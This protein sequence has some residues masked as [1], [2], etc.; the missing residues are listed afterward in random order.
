MASRRSPRDPAPESP[1][2]RGDAELIAATRDGDTAAYGELYERHV[3][4]ARRLGR[5]LARDAAAADDLVSETFAKVL[6]ALRNGNGPDLAFRAYL[7]TTLRHTFY[8]RARRDRRVEFTDDMSKHDPGVAFVDTAVAGQERRFAARAFQ[9]LPERWQV[10]LWHTEVEGESAAEIAPMLGLTPNAVAAL[11]YRAREKLRQMYLQEHL[12]AVTEAECRWTAGRLG[13]RVRGGLSSRDAGKVDDHLRGC[14][15]CGLALLELAE[16]NSGFRELLAFLVV[17]GSAPAYLGAAGAVKGAVVI[18]WWGGLTLGLAEA[19][20]HVIGWIRTGVE[21]VGSRTATATGAG[22]TVIAAVLA[23]VMLANG[24]APEPPQVQPPAEQP[25]PPVDPPEDDP[26]AEDPPPDEE[27]ADDP[28][29]EEPDEPD[30]AP[31]P[32]DYVI[33]TDPTLSTLV[34][35]ADGSLP[36]ELSVP[37]APPG[38]TG[39]VTEAARSGRVAT[40][41]AHTPSGDLRLV[42]TLPESIGGPGGDA[43]D[44]W[45]CTAGTGRVE[46]HR[47]ALRPGQ[48]TVARVPLTI[49]PRVTGFHDIHAEVTGPRI[50]GAAAL[51]VPIA[52][53]GTT[54]AFAAVDATGVTATGNGWLTCRPGPMCLHPLADNHTVDLQPYL[55]A[56]GRP[57]GLDPSAAASGARLD[58]PGGAEVLWAG[59]HWANSGD[60]P[61][62]SVR[63]FGPGG[64]AHDVAADREW[65]GVERP[66]RQAAADVTALVTG[67][68]DYWLATDSADIPSGRHQYA[69]WSMTVVYRVAGTPPRET[70][71][72]EGLA[73]PRADDELTVGIPAGGEVQVAYTLWDGDRTLL[74]DDLSVAGRPLGIPANL[75]HS[76]AYGALE[77][78]RRHTFGVDVG[79]CR[80]T[81]SPEPTVLLLDAGGDPLE[82]GVLAVATPVP[83]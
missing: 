39:T 11:S 10:V 65:T 24:P 62:P 72:Y 59:L 30:D 75:G 6:S 13:A 37:D 49:P 16:I 22:M 64:D 4:A 15:A 54:T 38:R 47:D 56:P 41:A 61:P 81:T 29:G 63:L 74:G 42:L 20:R 3:A 70:A 83:G 31:P 73:Q 79:V 77:G 46:C 53:P 68:G 25:E 8:D 18:G 34:A 1:H 55:D 40:V 21:R 44:G 58:L 7:L 66:V 14:A 71:V 26:P 27:P 43:G 60:T 82:V 76:S 51:R 50:E 35:G 69:G 19:V 78:P 57:G 48:S 23:L 33:T 36:V 52:P 9:R 17:G 32:A 5:I 45:D 28:P 2:P 12:H 80:T 67:A